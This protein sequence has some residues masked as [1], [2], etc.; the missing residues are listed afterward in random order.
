ME[1]HYEFTDSQFEKQF[2]NCTLPAQFFTHEAHLRLAWIYIDKYGLEQAIQLI[3]HQLLN[4]VDALG[5][6][7]KYNKTVTIAAVKVVNHF[8]L[9]SKA[10]NFSDFIA[11]NTQLGNNFKALIAQHY[12]TDIFNST[13]AKIEYLPP[14]LLP[15]DWA[16]VHNT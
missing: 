3:D 11:E 5:S 12:R 10:R 14:D 16:P 4:F 1:T 13:L 6:R 15:F 2:N 8:K 7:D 9:L